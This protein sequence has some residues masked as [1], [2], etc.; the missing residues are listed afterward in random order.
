MNIYEKEVYSTP[1][2]ATY[3]AH[4][5]IM[6]KERKQMDVTGVKKLLSFDSELFTMDTLMGILQVRGIELELKNLNLE[7]GEL[8]IMGYITGFEYD[9]YMMSE[10]D[11]KGLFGKLF[12]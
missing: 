11:S 6:M 5:N 10:D 1:K 3:I 12:R 7:K 9:D 8:A 4:H 2:Q